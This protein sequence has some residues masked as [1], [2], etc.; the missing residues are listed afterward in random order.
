MLLNNKSCTIYDKYFVD[1]LYSYTLKETSSDLS[2]LYNIGPTVDAN[3]INMNAIDSKLIPIINS[4]IPTTN[5]PDVWYPAIVNLANSSVN[6]KMLLKG[7]SVKNENLGIEDFITFDGKF[8]NWTINGSS[9]MTID[10]IINGLI[11]PYELEYGVLCWFKNISPSTD[12]LSSQL[13]N[14]KAL[15]LDQIPYHTVIRS[16]SAI[17]YQNE[18]KISVQI[19]PSTALV[20]K[21]NNLLQILDSSNTRISPS[22]NIEYVK[23]IRY[24][25]I[26]KYL[27]FKIKKQASET[28]TQYQAR[29]NEEYRT[30]K[31]RVFDTS[32]DNPQTDIVSL[33]YNYPN[34]KLWIANGE[35]FSY[36]KSPGDKDD[37]RYDGRASWSYLSPSLFHIY[38][39][40]YNSLSSHHIK[41]INKPFLNR[42][43]TRLFKKLCY[44]LA[45]SPILD[46][47]TISYLTSPSIQNIVNEFINKPVPDISTEISILKSVLAKI[48]E[49]LKDLSNYSNSNLAGN[50]INNKQE[51]FKK[52]LNKYGSQ[53]KI[54]R[55]T[56]IIY[57]NKLK[58]GP[59]FRMNQDIISK[60]SRQIS[61]AVIANNI[62]VNVGNFRLQSSMNENNSTFIVQ[63]TTANSSITI[64]IWDIEKKKMLDTRVIISAGDDMI[65]KLYNDKAPLQPPPQ[66]TTKP[67]VTEVSFEPKNATTPDYDTE[68]IKGDQATILWEKISGPDCLK[69]SD[70]N[71]DR[72]G[73]GF[74]SLGL[75]YDTSS[76]P[77]PTIYA[78]KPGRYVIQVTVTTSFGI[79]KDSF[80]VYVVDGKGFYEPG[81]KPKAL[82]QAN[83]I[84]LRP[85]NGL[86]VLC[87]NLRQFSFSKYGLFWP[88]YAD[89]SV[90]SRDS[91]PWGKVSS[92]G[93]Q[94]KKYAFE[95]DVSPNSS[96]HKP[97]T[98]SVTYKPGNTIITIGRV[99]LENM[100]DDNQDCYFCESFF[101]N[102]F[103]STGF[104]SDVYNE[105]S[106]IGQEDK[107]TTFK[108][109]D[110]VKTNRQIKSYGGFNNDKVSSIGVNIPDHPNI[111]STLP[112]ISGGANIFPMDQP[113]DQTGKP[114]H[115]CY[116]QDV[117][118]T[119]SVVFEKGVFHPFSGWFT[120]YYNRTPIYNNYISDPSI[121]DEIN[122]KSSVLKFSPGNRKT[123]MFKGQG[124][125]KLR[126]EY[127]DNDPLPI[128]Y[129]SSIILGTKKAAHD[130]EPPP[131]SDGCDEKDII[132]NEKLEPNDHDVN[133]G[134]RN[135]GENFGKSAVYS[136]EFEAEV[137]TSA[138]GG[139]T[140]EG[141]CLEETESFVQ[142]YTNSYNVTMKGAYVPD[143]FRTPTT[144]FR[145][146]LSGAEIKDIEVEI[147]F[148][149]YVNTKDLIVWL[150]IRTCAYHGQTVLDKKKNRDRLYHVASD[151]LNNSP[152]SSQYR[153]SLSFLNNMPSG[154]VKDYLF[155]LFKMN[156][157]PVGPALYPVD[158]PLT[159][160]DESSVPFDTSSSGMPKSNI[161]RLYLLNQDH[162][163]SNKYN[164]NLLF[165]D[166]ANKNSYSSNNNTKYLLPTQVK[167]V[168]HDNIIHLLP[169]T[170]AS[171]YS[172][173]DSKLFKN[174]INTNDLQLANNR[175]IKYK[176]LPLFKD[177]ER[178][179][180]SSTI[181]SL[182]IGVV[183]ETD[184]MKIYDRISNSDFLLGL[185]KT[186]VVSQSS[187]LENS[188]CS[189]NLILHIADD[190][191]KF[192]PIDSLGHI[193]YSSFDPSIPGY[194]FI[195][196]FKDKKYLIP[197]VNLNA[198]NDFI[199]GTNS[200]ATCVYSRE[201][202]NTSI[203]QP[204]IFNILPII[205]ILPAA[206]LVGALA[207]VA[208]VNSQLDILSREI[209]DF[210]SSLRRYQ[211]SEIFNRAIY[212]PKYDRYPH[213]DASKVLL[214]I[215]K[216][217]NI[218]YK[219]EASIF[220][221]TNSHILNRQKYQFVKLHKNILKAFSNFNYSVVSSVEDIL[222]DNY[223]KEI[224][225]P[226]TGGSSVE[227]TL[228]VNILSANLNVLINRKN[229]LEKKYKDKVMPED[230]AMEVKELTKNISQYESTL[231]S[232]GFN[233]VEKF[234]IIKLI[235]Q[236]EQ[237]ENGFYSI[238]DSYIP[239][240]LDNSV[241]INFNK[242]LQYLQY[243]S[244]INNKFLI[245]S[246]KI[247]KIEGLRAYHFFNI[248][249]SLSVLVDIQQEIERQ[250]KLENIDE[251]KRLTELAKTQKHIETATTIIGK[252]YIFKD[253]KHYTI[254]TLGGPLTSGGL[255][256]KDKPNCDIL[257]VFRTDAITHE[258]SSIS[259][260]NKWSFVVNND[261]I[262]S[263]KTPYLDSSTIGENAYG[264]GTSAVKPTI[265]SNAYQ[266]NKLQNIKDKLNSRDVDRFKN[267]N[268]QIFDEYQVKKLE[269]NIS[270]IGYA[271]ANDDFDYI[272]ELTNFV[273]K[274]SA[275][276]EEQQTKVN[277]DIARI[278]KELKYNVVQQ[279][280]NNFMF[281]DLKS[282]SF[283]QDV[284]PDF[285]E[286]IINEDYDFQIP[287]YKFTQQE[288]N[289]L[290]SRLDFLNS[291]NTLIERID[292]ACKNSTNPN[293]VTNFIKSLDPNSLN[294][295]DLET[296]ISYCPDDPDYCGL[297]GR[298]VASKCIKKSA[299]NLLSKRH[300][301][302]NTIL[303][304]IE[305]C[306]GKIEIIEET[307]PE[308]S[309]IVVAT[310]SVYTAYSGP[311]VLPYTTITIT[312]E[313]DKSIKFIEQINN[314]DYW[315]NI[316]PEQGCSLAY[317]ASA[318]I[319]IKAEYK[320]QLSNNL[321]TL[322][323][324][325]ICSNFSGPIGSSS[326]ADMLVK[327]EFAD[328]VY[329]TPKAK[330]LQ[331][332][333][334]Y[335][336]A[337]WPEL[338]DGIENGIIPFGNAYYVEREFFLN[339]MANEKNQLVKVKETYLLPNIDNS[340]KTE[341]DG[342]IDNKIKNI[343]NLDN[344][345]QLYVQFRKIPRKLKGSDNHYDRYTPNKFGQLGK[346]LT[347]APGG[348]NNTNFAIWRCVDR[349]TGKFITP[350]D[351]YRWQNEMIYRAF[352]GSEDG[353][354]HRGSKFTES[355]DAAD[356]IPY[357]Y[358]K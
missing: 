85:S 200:S 216:D 345:N 30:L 220:K 298:Y 89:C 44:F 280:H 260:F 221:Y 268:V 114:Y 20:K 185:T 60:C 285:G 97:A 193:N 111:G 62:E 8:K 327:S 311:R 251:V 52:L 54:D 99:I 106:L 63:D 252:N 240:K 94:I 122:N 273:I 299:E 115:L 233:G 243:N 265:L 165:S 117:P 224:H 162:I 222:D 142:S 36:F 164:I 207:E 336:T 174:I 55:E 323:A 354:E 353:A 286:I 166:N 279:N 47:T 263:N 256:G 255:I 177:E 333:A 120:N 76:D 190:A 352:F 344:T 156:D 278:M 167:A 24:F 73:G 41:Y 172:D 231:D 245:N 39:E 4:S 102:M 281:I 57:K 77:I 248:N 321:I 26:E 275:N 223:I 316:D 232:I 212:V 160:Q 267:I 319:L 203:T 48:S 341:P 346:S 123:L 65:V 358:Y 189:W 161:Y 152:A 343:Y 305:D 145:K 34:L 81:K 126:N 183:G 32:G 188:I 314:D 228:N 313:E 186:D 303:K 13:P 125:Y 150:D 96:N 357:D 139:V 253:N 175:F 274:T 130:C 90:Y 211:Q 191:P 133:S 11:V 95:T 143:E 6:N 25:D 70:L 244:L 249:D 109:P 101:K 42:K 5:K 153:E 335:P 339:M 347:P 38:R 338:G 151:K 218:W 199:Y 12:T 340:E 306:G 349:N 348:P 15:T 56:T 294:I 227:E 250:K 192:K 16:S 325:H 208:S 178:N 315:I 74:T 297:P 293:C 17:S 128:F 324:R 262:I 225:I 3:S 213:G 238:N 131:T 27:N 113:F 276:T 179:N 9:T 59:N 92:F 134:Y 356:W 61:N 53:I 350:P 300:I 329:I 147:N 22:G 318:K 307:D 187:I 342:E 330:I 105:F 184:E 197:P 18:E 171:G 234:D 226:I 169:S 261:N 247:I 317:D 75:R 144:R 235:N 58:Y 215:S 322:N 301:E 258:N 176:N 103:T 302:R 19:S 309:S 296:Y 29:R 51:L 283:K 100:L 237:T 217:K 331:Q 127:L 50:F 290:G 198:P 118:V 270:T 68:I 135:V 202:L 45:T 110:N 140:S 1:D 254:L 159:D 82:N 69:F 337:D 121:Y 287:K 155:D 148:L 104:P 23:S 79:A 272:F 246:N 282:D 292:K 138:E 236:T 328:Y 257:L 288:M 67:V 214:N 219:T 137:S 132:A 157:N 284:I 116:L 14:D 241:E 334:K 141:Y 277:K 259:N 129:K 154:Y 64:P 209:V 84:N 180:R 271:Y 88:S 195:S 204:P 83:S 10:W 7:S 35:A 194:S 43:Q 28:D 21:S 291:K 332:M 149:N 49:A 295:S 66:D 181:F 304:Y 2:I 351:Y 136:D 119:G 170:S 264:T 87:P 112:A 158:D 72:I 33:S 266:K 205:T 310:K 182:G 229:N 78:K 146:S 86:I 91:N 108:Y 37:A 308:D 210:F 326:D 320:C 168:E 93:D 98:L 230:V 201:S 163:E 124:F 46:R 289:R 80:I 71:L 107:E 206:S 196:N 242:Y 40:I 173:Y 269:Q 312:E 31:F 239:E 355:R